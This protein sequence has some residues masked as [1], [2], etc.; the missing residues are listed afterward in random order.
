MFI[1]DDVPA[2]KPKINVY[3]FTYRLPTHDQPGPKKRA[4]LEQRALV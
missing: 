4:P 1:L 2:A 3:H